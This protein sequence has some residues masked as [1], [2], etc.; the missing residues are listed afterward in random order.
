MHGLRSTS[1]LLRAPEKAGEVANS[2]S[3]PFSG[4][5]REC[6][7]Y[8]ALLLAYKGRIHVIVPFIARKNGTLTA[9]RQSYNDVHG[10]YRA[11]IEQLFACYGIG[12]WLGTF[13]VAAPMSCTSQSVFGCILRN[14]AFAG[15]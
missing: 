12:A 10:W 9:R 5:P 7:G 3:V 4:D 15:R 6:R 2:D 14:F 11:R 1:A 13:G 8:I